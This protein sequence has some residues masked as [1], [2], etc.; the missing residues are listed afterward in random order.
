MG[1]NICLCK[2]LHPGRGGTAWSPLALARQVF[3]NDWSFQSTSS[4]SIP[5]MPADPH[6]S[7]LDQILTLSQEIVDECPSCAGKAAQIAMWAR[8][9]RERRPSR[10]ELEALVDATCKG[11]VPDDRRKLLIEDLRALVRFAE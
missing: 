2:G 6:T 4:D 9:I 1:M 5:P 10:L 11:F 8:E 3:S 7:P